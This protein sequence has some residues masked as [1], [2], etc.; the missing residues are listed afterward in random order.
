MNKL[1]RYVDSFIKFECVIFGTR[2]YHQRGIDVSV[3]SCTTGMRLA[4]TTACLQRL[5]L[6]MFASSSVHHQLTSQRLLHV[7]QV[8]VLDTAP[9][10]DLTGTPSEHA[11]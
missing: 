11:S 10:M 6:L 9:E 1:N 2:K 4:G 8:S 3:I 7:N 5:T